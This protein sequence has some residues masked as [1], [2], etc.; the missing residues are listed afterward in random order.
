[1][2]LYSLI[3]PVLM[4][5]DAEKAHGLTL[6]GL[7]TGLG[8]SCAFTHATLE[9]QVFG[10]SFK[11]PLG[12]AAGFD[13]DAQVLPALLKM[14]FGFV[15]AGTVTPRPQRGN[16]KPRVFR[17]VKNECVINRMGFPGQGLDVFAANL[18]KDFP[19][20]KGVVGANIGINKDTPA[21]ESDYAACILRLCALCDY[22]TIN[23]SSPNTQGL[24]DLQAHAQLNN[25]LKVLVDTRNA[26][27]V[28]IPLLLK[29]AP[30]LDARARQD[31]ASLVMLHGIDGLVVSNTTLARPGTLSAEV[32]QEKGGLSGRLLA[33][34][35]TAVIADFYRL[36]EGRL[37]IVGVGGIASAQDAYDKIR[38]GASLVQLYTALV[39]QGPALIPRI[40]EGLVALLEKDGFTSI[41]QAVGTGQMPLKKVV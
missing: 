22:M 21:P 12:L 39:F 24:R 32:R 29:V 37:P 13:K 31:I 20:R 19:S 7:R 11:N 36:T 16:D 30:D 28:R 5:M 1:M 35:S 17:D 41:A 4:R 38:A 25:L 2:S 18:E 26:Q 9:T 14:G 8:P 34:F 15:E 6:A 40:L 3:R 27:D 23:V 10:L 33:P